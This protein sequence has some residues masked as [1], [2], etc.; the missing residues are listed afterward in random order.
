[1][2]DITKR[3]EDLEEVFAILQKKLEKL[4]AEQPKGRWKPE[5]GKKY[6]CASFTGNIVDFTW[7]GSPTDIFNFESGNCFQTEREAEIHKSLITSEKAQVVREL[8]MYAAMHNSPID[9]NDGGQEKWSVPLDHAVGKSS[10]ATG[11]NLNI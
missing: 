5:I 11:T 4:K 8:E 6:W 7:I 2:N 1:M 9:W 3:I 10:V